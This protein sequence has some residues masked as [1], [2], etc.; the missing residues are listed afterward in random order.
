MLYALPD[1]CNVSDRLRV[2]VSVMDVSRVDPLR[3]SFHIEVEP[4]APP[5]PPGPTSPPQHTGLTG[6]PNIVEVRHEKWAQYGF[7]EQSALELKH[8]EDDTLDMFINMDNIHLRNEVV[9]RRNTD[10]ELLKFWFKYGLCLLAL[11]MLYQQRQSE[12][13]PSSQGTEDEPSSE[14]FASIA[15]ACRGLAVTV[16][17]VISQLSRG[18]THGKLQH[19][20][21][22][23]L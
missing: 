9:R 17:P 22:D 23:T 3:S 21:G 20:L 19:S 2:E 11:G 5:G 4:E 7:D 6:L 15:E 1:T 18:Q 16:V 12:K 10:P 8:G 13:H 14:H